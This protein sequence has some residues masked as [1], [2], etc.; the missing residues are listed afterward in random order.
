MNLDELVNMYEDLCTHYRIHTPLDGGFEQALNKDYM[1]QY[2]LKCN[3][4]VYNQLTHIY[5]KS[6]GNRFV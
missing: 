2:N 6:N 4:Y 5:G 3:E 1:K